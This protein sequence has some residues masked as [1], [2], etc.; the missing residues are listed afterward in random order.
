M[1]VVPA[2]MTRS[3]G[4]VGFRIPHGFDAYSLVELAGV[5]GS[6]TREG[7]DLR[8]APDA[9]GTP[10]LRPT[11]IHSRI[12]P[13]E[14]P[15]RA[16]A[17]PPSKWYPL[18]VNVSPCIVARFE[19]AGARIRTWELLREQIL[20]LP[21]L[22]ARPPRLGPATVGGVI[23]SSPCICAQFPVAYRRKGP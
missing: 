15:W 7:R 21:P 18:R 4:R 10:T 1:V 6:V 14:I 9:C 22:A 19:S 13:E 3:S 20:S 2:P 8:I 16:R 11:S 12:P 5:T 17:G 23:S